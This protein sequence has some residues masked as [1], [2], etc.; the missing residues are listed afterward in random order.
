MNISFNTHPSKGHLGGENWHIK[1]FLGQVLAKLWDYS[2]LCA[3]KRFSYPKQ[4]DINTR[5]FSQH[6]L[7]FEHYCIKWNGLGRQFIMHLWCCVLF[8]K[9]FNSLCLLDC[10]CMKP[11]CLWI[12]KVIYLLTQ[13][14]NIWRRGIIA[15]KCISHPSNIKTWHYRFVVGSPHITSTRLIWERNL[16]KKEKSMLVWIAWMLWIVLLCVYYL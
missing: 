14:Q 8:V 6:N 4:L 10:P 5:L 12:N 3:T 13:V 11:T 15:Y 1:V 2:I 7:Y 16:D 9:H